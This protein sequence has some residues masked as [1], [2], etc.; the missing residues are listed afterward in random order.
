[1]PNRSGVH[2]HCL[3]KHVEGFGFNRNLVSNAG[4][5]HQDVNAT[6]FFYNMCNQFLTV[7]CLSNVALHGK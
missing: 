4:V 2:F 7:A 5:I 3:F 1:M 6:K